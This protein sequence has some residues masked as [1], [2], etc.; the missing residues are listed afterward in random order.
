ILLQEEL[1]ISPDENA[2]SLHD[3]LMEMGAKLVVKTLDGLAENSITEQPQ[4][5]VAEPKNA[6]KIFKE[7]TRIHWNQETVKV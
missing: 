4:P 2:G 3:R 7:D 1:P 5:Q 6:F